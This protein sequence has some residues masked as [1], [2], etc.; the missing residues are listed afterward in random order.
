MSLRD[1]LRP[2]YSSELNWDS[3]NELVECNQFKSIQELVLDL[4]MF[5]STIYHHLKKRKIEQARHLDFS[6]SW[7][8]KDHM[9]VV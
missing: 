9:L 5:Q 6:Y 7:K 8:N 3:L 4:S 1:E 2:G